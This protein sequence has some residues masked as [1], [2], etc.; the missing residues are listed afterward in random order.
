M[1][2]KLF[3]S[4]TALLFVFSACNN[5]LLTKE[6]GFGGEVELRSAVSCFTVEAI[7]K[8]DYDK[9]GVEYK[10]SALVTIAKGITLVKVKPNDLELKFSAD[11]VP[12]T[13]TLSVKNGNIFSAY[14]FDTECMQGK[15]HVFSG[16]DVSG[17]KY[18]AFVAAPVKPVYTVTFVTV[19]GV[20]IGTARCLHIPDS[21]PLGGVTPANC[22]KLYWE[23]VQRDIQYLNA[24]YVDT[25]FNVFPPYRAIRDIFKVLEGAYLN[26]NGVETDVFELMSGT[27]KSNLTVTVFVEQPQPC[28]EPADLSAITSVLEE[29]KASTGSYTPDSWANL[30]HMIDSIESKLASKQWTVCDD[31][32]FEF[33]YM[34]MALQV[35]K[36]NL[37]RNDCGLGQEHWFSYPA[38]EW[39]DTI[40]MGNYVYTQLDADSISAVAGN[41]V[42]G[43]IFCA[44]AVYRLN[45]WAGYV[46]PVDNQAGLAALATVENWFLG[47]G[48]KLSPIFILYPSG[49]TPEAQATQE[50]LEAAKL[51]SGWSKCLNKDG[52]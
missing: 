10:G 49:S 34:L 7:T 17:I 35:V 46:T 4:L 31:L 14:T 3:C 43:Q 42:A 15:T 12:G 30:Q 48:R 28:N 1:K 27:I 51:L 16:K 25:V 40:N 45:V 18:G 38:V 36:G 2:L 32:E 26:G 39:P 47:L 33:G 6:A 20:F 29:A 21:I 22:D 24:H 13:I 41:T 23:D 44:Y 11:V 37:W 50:V 5:D 52:Q 19:D 8:S 9:A